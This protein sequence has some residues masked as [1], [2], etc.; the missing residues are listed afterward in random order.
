MGQV[1]RDGHVIVGF[2]AGVAEHHPLVSGS[3]VFGIAVVDAPVDVVAL[4]MDGR[5]NAAAVA[6]EL[7]FGFCVADVVDGLP[8]YCLEVDVFFRPHF[9]HD[10]H[11]SRSVEC[12]YCTPCVFV[13]GQ[14]LVEQ[15]V[16]DLVGNLIRVSFRYRFR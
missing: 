3:L 2:V 6:V 9:A 7:I 10:H 14:K 16:T 4:F 13:V 5:E 1:E 8:G 11:L 15:C 12:F